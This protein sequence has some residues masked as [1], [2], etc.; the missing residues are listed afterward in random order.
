MPPKPGLNPIEQGLLA[1][2]TPQPVPQQTAPV[3]PV[4]GQNSDGSGVDQQALALSRAILLQEGGGKP[5]YN[6]KGASGEEG[7]GQWMPGEFAADATA[8]GLD[9]NDMSPENQDKVVYATVKS[10]KD[11]GMQPAEIASEW[12]SGSPD[13]YENHSGVNSKGVSYD[14]PAYVQG[15]KKY[16]DQL[17]AQSGAQNDA[18]SGAGNVG[19]NPSDLPSP[20]APGQPSVPVQQGALNGY[21]PPAPPSTD[22]SKATPPPEDNNIWDKIADIAFPIA[23]DV[24]HDIAGDS[25]KSVLQQLG[26]AGLSALWFLPF[27]DIAEAAGAGA[28]AL[29]VGADAAKTAG[30]IGTG[31]GTGYASDVASNA[32]QGQTGGSLLKPGLGTALGGAL[33]VAGLGLGEAF[34]KIAGQQ[35]AVDKVASAYSDALAA[36]KSGVKA[37]GKGEELSSKA[38]F[39]ANAGIAP[40]TQEMNGRRVFTTGENSASQQEIQQRIQA[41]TDLRDQA[42][43]KEPM[44]D[45]GNNTLRVNP[46]PTSNLETVRANALKQAESQFSGTARVSA[47]D[48]INNEFDVLKSQYATDSDGN[49][50]LKNMN[51]IKKYLQSQTNYDTTRPANTTQV[52]KV[53]SAMAR[54]QVEEDAEKADIPGVKKLNEYIQQH[55]D[56]LDTLNR[57]NGQTIKGGR[58]GT[59]VKEGI[60]AALGGSV[61]GALGGGLIGSSAGVL[62]GAYAGHL[63]SNWL[64][65]MAVSGPM[66]A[67][68]IGRM[69]SEDPEVVQ[70]FLQYVGR[71]GEKLAPQLKPVQ[72]SAAGLVGNIL[73]KTP[74]S[75]IIQTIRK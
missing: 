37:M 14:T 55:I 1:K 58:L 64:Q 54:Q 73:N 41:L 56:A 19:L 29:G 36:T 12:N 46:A 65:K 8:A 72:S 57:I 31:V 60:G 32:S 30:L 21:P 66:T 3:V 33:P 74:G 75:K 7:A 26:D 20:V 67:A 25:S 22:T 15:V 49:V 51:K 47:I 45:I 68:T 59:Y 16:Y 4:S 2:A 18:A 35:S 71:Q 11:K 62:G 39:L 27:G 24:K 6:A 44:E 17:T 53:M 69:T 52:N 48:H 63:L 50:S 38:D 34:N 5:A 10:Q 42:I 40:E 28:R 9:P 61:S 13:N 43:E 70:Q 23:V